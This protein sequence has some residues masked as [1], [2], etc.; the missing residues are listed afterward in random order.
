MVWCDLRWKIYGVCRETGTREGRL[1][2]K[3]AFREKRAEE[4]NAFIGTRVGGPGSSVERPVSIGE[5]K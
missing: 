3:V 4:V 2:F 1:W 5:Y